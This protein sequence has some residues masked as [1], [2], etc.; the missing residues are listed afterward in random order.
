MWSR[1]NVPGPEREVTEIVRLC[2]P[3][4]RAEGVEQRAQLFWWDI[5]GSSEGIRLLSMRH[6]QVGF[7]VEVIGLETLVVP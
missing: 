2:A 3:G 4:E 1:K 5:Q 7:C 6:S